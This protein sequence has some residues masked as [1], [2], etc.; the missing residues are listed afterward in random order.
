MYFRIRSLILI[1]IIGFALD[2]ARAQGST[3]DDLQKPCTITGRVTIDGRGAPGVVV[4]LTPSILIRNLQSILVGNLQSI[5]TKTDKS[6][7]FRFANVGAGNPP[8]LSVHDLEGTYVFSNRN[9]LLEWGIPVTVSPGANIT[10]VDFALTRGAVIT[11]HVLDERGRPVADEQVTCLWSDP[12]GSSWREKGGPVQTNSRGYFRFSGLPTG[13]YRLVFRH[14]DTDRYAMTYYPN[15]TDVAK[16]ATLEIKA[17][18]Q[19]ANIDIR[20][21]PRTTF[22][23]SGRVIDGH[24]NQPLPNLP[25][26]YYQS[27]DR[28]QEYPTKRNGFVGYSGAQ[29]EIQVSGLLP[30]KYVAYIG[31]EESARDLYCDPA[32]F[33]VNE[34]DVTGVQIKVYRGVSLSGRAVIEET[35]D[36]AALSKLTGL[37]L[38]IQHFPASPTV[39]IPLDQSAQIAA[40]GSFRLSG[41]RPGKSRIRPWDLPKGL[42]LWSVEWNGREQREW[43]F[44]LTPGEQ[45][46][47]VRVVIAYSAGA[48][49]GQIKVEG[50]ESF[51]GEWMLFLKG[52]RGAP[53]LSFINAVDGQGRFALDGLAP[54]TYTV[55]ASRYGKSEGFGQPLGASQFEYGTHADQTVTV[56]ND[57]ETTALIIVKKRE[58]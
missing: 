55:S 13:S 6:G 3:Q 10:G 45:L 18:T 53:T 39:F 48:I 9:G 46:T 44:D 21:S 28:G 58:G 27:V 51:T 12:S 17:G 35:T 32:V 20:L 36:P 16:A 1:L 42:T 7:Y 31:N 11:G 22:A 54:G 8:V 26:R 57:G 41:L 23:V 47:G 14:A 2:G 50:E 56:S 15:A 29:G 43:V 19:V 34:K 5:T 25:W 30:G 49:R 37:R 52:V 40:D 4:S 33:E 24:T 38:G